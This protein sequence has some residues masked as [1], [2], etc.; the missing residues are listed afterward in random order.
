MVAMELE[1]ECGFVVKA[2]ISTKYKV[3]IRQA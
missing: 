3:S 2:G 1:E